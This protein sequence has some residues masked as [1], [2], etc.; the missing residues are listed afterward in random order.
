MINRFITKADI[1][2]VHNAWPIA[3]WLIVHS[4]CFYVR[5]FFFIFWIVHADHCSIC[6]YQPNPVPS[7][8]YEYSCCVNVFLSVFMNGR[9]GDVWKCGLDFVVCYFVCLKTLLVISS[10]TFGYLTLNDANETHIFVNSSIKKT[11]WQ[12]KKFKVH[13]TI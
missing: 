2:L 9:A 6:V 1:D 4:P 7:F 5:S 8:N 3:H 13:E 11:N 10:K 12:R